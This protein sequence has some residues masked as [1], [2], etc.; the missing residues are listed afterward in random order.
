[1]LVRGLGLVLLV[2][3]H[4]EYEILS[5]RIKEMLQK[6][7]SSLTCHVPRVTVRDTSTQFKGGRQHI[8]VQ[9]G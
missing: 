4:H 2:Y 5:N 8:V 7:R 3:I 6:S 9:E 1:M